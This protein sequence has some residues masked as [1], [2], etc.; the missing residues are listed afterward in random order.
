M[1]DQTK[2]KKQLIEELKA[3]LARRSAIVEAINHVL[4]ETLLCETDKEVALICL[5]IAQDLTGSKFGWIG[6][7]N[8]SGRLDT[9]ALSNPGWVLCRIP[10]VNSTQMIR[11]MEIRGIWGRVLKDG[12]SLITNDPTTHPD[13]VGLPSGHPELIS[14]LGVPLKDAGQTIGMIALANKPSGYELPD[15][16]AIEMLSTALLEA[17]KRKRVEEHL[18]VERACFEQLF[19]NAPEAIIVGDDEGRISLVNAEFTMLFGYTQEE[20]AGQLVD[21]LIVPDSLRN[22]GRSIT[23]RVGKGERIA[24]E[25]RRQNKDGKEFDVSLLCQPIIIDKKIVGV[26]GIYR[27]ITE[28][29]KAEAEIQKRVKELEDFYD[30]AV[31][32]ELRMIELKEQIEELNEE[33]SKYKTLQDK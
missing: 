18:K 25:T 19:Q 2:T 3:L 24:L 30:M 29:K 23:K 10:E 20:V 9:I 16:E 14:F 33:L 12:K 26:Y 5:A 4:R 22:E 21:E 8:Q 32:R 6:E 31:G 17:L 28:R 1:K 11:N 15:Q 27:D 13:R 7:V